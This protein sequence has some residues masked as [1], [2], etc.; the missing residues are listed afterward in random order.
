MIGIWYFVIYALLLLIFWAIERTRKI[1]KSNFPEVIF[2]ISSYFYLLSDIK[3]QSSDILAGEFTWKDS[4]LFLIIVGS[5]FLFIG[6]ILAYIKNQDFLEKNDLKSNLITEQTKVKKIK[7]EYYSLCSD[8]IKDIFQDFFANSPD[9]NSR[10]SLYKHQGTHFSLLGRCSDNP[11]YSKRGQETYS[12]NEGFIAIGW[13]N[14]TFEIHG[15]PIWKK[16][17]ASYKSFM[18]EN[19]IIDENRLKNI[20][21]KSRSFYI[22]RFDNQGAANPHGII[23]FE[24]MNENQI[25]TDIIN[26]IF[27]KHQSQIISLLRSM[28]SLDKI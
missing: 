14:K 5:I 7:D 3:S 23:V 11:A 20:T 19:C 9:G 10:V 22:Y 21:M 6:F 4:N 13:Q 8:Y 24:R 25:S 26:D 2:A 12:D 16:N 1:L 15:A 17:G 28:K 27:E 18:K